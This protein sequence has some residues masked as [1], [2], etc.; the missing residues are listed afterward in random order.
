MDQVRDVHNM[1][2]GCE[3]ANEAERDV[4]IRRAS[5]FNELHEAAVK[6]DWAI[7]VAL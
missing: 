3:I 2:H 1:V 5:G 7:L 6:K 4:G